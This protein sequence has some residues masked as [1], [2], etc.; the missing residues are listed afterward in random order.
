MMLTNTYEKYKLPS[1]SRIR[2]N[3]I[4]HIHVL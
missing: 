4:I 2:T 1:I 3:R